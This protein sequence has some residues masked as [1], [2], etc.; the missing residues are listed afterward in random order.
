M[1]GSP[2]IFSLQPSIYGF[3]TDDKR[4]KSPRL[5]DNVDYISIPKAAMMSRTNDRDLGWP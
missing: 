2:K 4:A 1:L 3:P 5:I